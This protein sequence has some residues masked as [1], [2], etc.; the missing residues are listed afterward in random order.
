VQKAE[1]EAHVEAQ[2]VEADHSPNLAS[3]VP[4]LLNL[5]YVGPVLK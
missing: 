4:A 5:A 1:V 3:V 2:K